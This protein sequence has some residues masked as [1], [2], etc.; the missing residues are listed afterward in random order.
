[1][2]S[3]DVKIAPQTNNQGNYK[4]TWEVAAKR[5]QPAYLVMAHGRD[6]QNLDSYSVKKVDNEVIGQPGTP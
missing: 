6:P 4:F 2:S 5:Q 1:M 3:F